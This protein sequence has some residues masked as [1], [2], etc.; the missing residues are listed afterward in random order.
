[1]TRYV[2][3][4]KF[5]HDWREFAIVPAADPDAAI[6]RARRCGMRPKD[7]PMK[8]VPLKVTKR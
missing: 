3:S 5:R 6:A 8:A 2:V 7:R 1:M 4:E